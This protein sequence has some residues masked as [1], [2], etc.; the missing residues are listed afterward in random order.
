MATSLIALGDMSVRQYDGLFSLN[1]LHKASGG[2][3][4]HRPNQF[5]RRKETVELVDAINNS[6]AQIRAFDVLRGGHG[7]TYACKELVI[8]YAAWISAAFHLKVI[9]VFLS[10]QAP[11]QPRRRAGAL[12][13]EFAWNISRLSAANQRGALFY[14]R[15]LVAGQGV[16]L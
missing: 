5:M 12:P 3:A 15:G 4:N 1:D 6:N 14:L 9:R 16:V 8:A 10:T 2:D 7:G 11:A 13:A